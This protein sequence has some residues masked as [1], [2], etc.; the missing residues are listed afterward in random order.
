MLKPQESE[1][2]KK[3]AGMGIGIS[4][5]VGVVVSGMIDGLAG[6]IAGMAVAFLGT[7]LAVEARKARQRSYRCD[8]CHK[9]ES[10]KIR[11][12]CG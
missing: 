12:K 4:L 3:N 11:Y 9:I 5:L 6:I 7:G 1:V 8:V 10:S 2:A